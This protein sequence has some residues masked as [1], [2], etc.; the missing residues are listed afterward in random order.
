MFTFQAGIGRRK[1]DNSGG[2]CHLPSTYT[3][4]QYLLLVSMYRLSIYAFPCND[5]INVVKACEMCKAVAVLL[6]CSSMCSD[7]ALI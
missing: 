3:A 1:I 5:C 2:K 6:V 4:L 7:D